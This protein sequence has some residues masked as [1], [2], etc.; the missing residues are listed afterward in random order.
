MTRAVDPEEDREAVAAVLAGDRERFTELVQ[1]YQERLVNYLSRM[2]GNYD[3]AHDVVQEV[4]LK[5]YRAL[6][7]FDPS[8]RFSTWIFRVARNAAIDRV[9][10]RRLQTVSLTVP[11][12]DSGGERQWELPGDEKTP[13]QRARQ[14]ERRE[15]VLQAVRG[16]PWEYRELIMLRHYAELSYNEIAEL[17]EMPLGTVK[18][19]LFRARRMLEERLSAEWLG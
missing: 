14:E 10:R 16:L 11:D 15:A 3:E 19:K 4:F 18:N 8:Y 2:L 13:Y 9:R 6:D 5:V 12:P 7:T 1:R 17:K